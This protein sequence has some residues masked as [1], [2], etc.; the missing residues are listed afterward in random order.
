MIPVILLLLLLKLAAQL[1]LERLNRAH[2]I[3]HADQVPEAFKHVVDNDT[4][5]KS[6]KYTLARSR[7]HR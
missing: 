2:V 4:Y 3:A 7:L 5:A 6:V 1:W